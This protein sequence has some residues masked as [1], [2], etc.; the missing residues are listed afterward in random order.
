MTET[1]STRPQRL[2]LLLAAINF[3]NF[4]DR[5][6]LAAL[7]EPIK[8]HFALSDTQLGALNSAFEIVYPFA[9]LALGMVADRWVRKRVIAVGVIVWSLAT[10]ATGAAGSYLALALTRAGVGLGCGGYGPAAMALLS[11]A[12]PS[13]R[14]SR[15]VALHDVGLMLGSALGYLLGGLLGQALGWPSPFLIA[16]FPGLVL[17]VLAWRIREP[18]RGASEYETLGIEAHGV[19]RDAAPRINLN[20]LRQLLAL[21]TLQVVYLADVLIAFAS[22]GLIF[23]LTSFLVRLHDFSL[24]EA[25]TLAGVLQVVTGLI[26]I[27]IG[28][29]VADRWTA[30][31][32]GGRMLTL[33]AGFLIGTPL[34]VIGI[35]TPSATLF[36]V[37]A[38]LAVICYTVYFPCLTPQIHDVTPPELRATALAINILLGHA[39][40][41]FLSAPFIGLLSDLTGDLRLALLMVPAVALLG[42]LVALLG[43]RSAGDDRQRMLDSLQSNNQ[44]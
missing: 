20:V 3:T 10:M 44:T 7:A 15:A 21:R 18:R 29:W 28:G 22:G 30:R 39:L 16:G 9:A 42:G 17:G 37:A 34:A 43:V 14:R 2:L 36:A 31:H 35:L 25:G 5:Q 32:P 4:F 33:S 8:E 26:G 1:P 12:F 6:L 13:A 19:K 11:D 38:G 24:R 41:N 27:L 23:W 40:G